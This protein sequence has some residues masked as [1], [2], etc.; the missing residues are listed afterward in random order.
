MP[1]QQDGIFPDQHLLNHVRDAL[2]R[3]PSGACVMVGSGFSRNALK[4][5]PDTPDIPLWPDLENEFAGSLPG[6]GA[7][8]EGSGDQRS[9]SGSNRALE[10]AQQ[11]E[12][13]FG[14]ARLHE[15]LLRSVRDESFQP[16]E[17][18][19]RLLGLPW[20]DVFTTNWDTLL[21]RCLPLPERSYDVVTDADH[22]P[23]VA[24]P[25]IVKLH[26]SLPGAFPLIVTAD[27]YGNY[28]KRFA[29]F[30]NTVQQ[31]MM[32]TVV[33]LLGFSGDDPNF[34]Q[35]LRWVRENLRDH[36]PRIYVA[37]WLSLDG[38]S[39][40]DEFR[41]E[42]VVPIDLARHPQASG[43]PE[44]LKYAKAAEWLLLS[45]EHGRPY[46]AEDWPQPVALGRR[47]ISVDL[48]PVETVAVKS[49]QEEPWH[50]VSGK[51]NDQEEL[52]GVRGLLRIWR[53]NRRCFP[54]WLALPSERAV[55]M[56]GVTDDWQPV[57]IKALP[58]L[59]GST[60]R[61]AALRELVWRREVQ[62]DPLLQELS[63]P[64]AA[65][66]QEVDCESRLVGGRTQDG[67]G[68]SEW[69]RLR[70]YWREL[71]AALVT[72]AR[73][74][75]DEE[76]FGQWCER[77]SAFSAE[78]EEIAE[79]LHHEK[80]LWALDHQDLPQLETLLREWKPMAADP[81]WLLRK[82]ALL[83]E[84]GDLEEARR[85]ALGV[86][87]AV[88]RWPE[89]ATS[90][91]GR[92]REAWA[93]SLAHGTDPDWDEIV[94]RL[95][96][97]QSRFRELARHRCEPWAEFRTHEMEVRGRTESRAYRPFDLGVRNVTSLS[98][99]NEAHYRALAALRAIRLTEIVGSPSIVSGDLLVRCAEA[100]LPYGPEWAAALSMRFS[101]ETAD[102]RFSKTLSRWRV[103]FMP[104]EL[105]RGLAEAQHCTIALALDRLQQGRVKHD[106]RRIWL[107]RLEA[108]VEALSRFVLRLEPSEV[109]RALILALSLYRDSRIHSRI[110]L[111][112]AQRGL[113]SRS[114]EA[115]PDVQRQRHALSLISLPIV[116]VDDFS[117]DTPDHLRDP[118]QV[119]NSDRWDCP[120]PERTGG[121]EALWS[122]IV[123]LVEAGLRSGGRAR[124]RAALRLALL[125]DWKVLTAKEKDRLASALWDFGLD[126]DRLP[127]KT[128]LHRW[129]F[130]RLPEP[131]P[132][133]AE[134][135]LRATWAPG[136]TGEAAER[137]PGEK[138]LA[139]AGIALQR[140][141]DFGYTVDITSAERVALV[142]GIE[143]WAEEGLRTHMPWRGQQRAREQRHGIRAISALLLELD[144]SREATA[145]LVDR[146]RAM[147]PGR[148]P[149][150]E[151]IPGIVRSDPGQTDDAA[152]L[153]RVG[154]GGGAAEQKPQC[155]SACHG[156][157]LWLRASTLSGP[158]MQ[159]PPDSLVF[160]LGVIIAAHRWLALSNAL[161]IAAWI[162][163]NGTGE[164]RDLLH[165]P[166]L[167][168]LA[169]L[170]TALAFREEPNPHP[171]IELPEVV[172]EDEV[173]VPWLRS[174]CLG[175][176]AAMDGAGLGGETA[177]AGWLADAKNDPLPEL[178]R[179]KEL[180]GRRSEDEGDPESA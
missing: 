42:N 22:L 63:K 49:P 122:E 115:L 13:A 125:A 98:F 179:R 124:E 171:L 154:L 86:L 77:L 6:S 110:S 162:F 111:L 153:L 180:L 64:V 36:A 177:V 66:L 46:P 174:H 120:A 173:D 88:R 166:C 78:D 102:R 106:G 44:P 21:E 126:D 12:D 75:F 68:D 164:H 65:V 123:Q 67:L 55:Q 134:R 161:E 61:L 40:R 165:S 72:A 127:L 14:R 83:A 3:S 37:N 155:A 144:V 132:G 152:A 70:R 85:L 91:G 131:A 50:R 48:M 73:F 60:E 47:R 35:W 33:L 149:V 112:R 8:R 25:R 105:V 59:R 99:S 101:N 167:Q 176:A 15:F 90:L 103:A 26:G 93:L 168:G 58:R 94:P 10:L 54:H 7:D 169:F 56:R 104:P 140:L 96:E 130:L 97:L 62:L 146:V 147:A 119:L 89:E 45:L 136:T 108:A 18:H 57:I 2:W 30:V 117:V 53:H 156:L 151:L 118:G 79:R 39:V 107:H 81:A 76:A 170:R 34:R 24:P 32:E 139:S 113:L 16:G 11:Y 137:A 38:R 141:P 43:W 80:C 51:P 100:L 95:Q 1:A 133:M 82:G 19:R 87:E 157:Y 143:R 92:S 31:A 20:R 135:R 9:A 74:E 138:A 71:A 69:P 41:D 84:T 158:E 114:W 116:G 121:N 17:L 109:E 52:E 159:P 4:V 142:R 23:V 29:P 163:E 5:R 160:E 28:P 178:R 150:Y 129:V 27:D 128:G 175:L 145:L 148:T 172:S